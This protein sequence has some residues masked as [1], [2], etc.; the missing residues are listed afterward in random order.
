MNP[1]NSSRKN[2]RNNSW[3]ISRW[4]R[5][6]EEFSVIFGKFT[7]PFAELQPYLCAQMYCEYRLLLSFTYLRQRR[8]P[9]KMK[10]HLH[11]W[12]KIEKKK[13]I[14][15]HYPNGDMN[16]KNVDERSFLFHSTKKKRQNT[17]FHDDRFNSF[18]VH[19]S[20]NNESWT[21]R[22]LAQYYLVNDVYSWTKWQL[23]ICLKYNLFST[24]NKVFFIS[25]TSFETFTKM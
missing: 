17:H 7:D 18:R 8:E 14:I 6:T 4:N 19:N 2:L 16:R 10:D 23:Y 5:Y 21:V 20:S 12:K 24:L 11:T 15:S 9:N 3:S 1:R 13:H 22:V 25:V